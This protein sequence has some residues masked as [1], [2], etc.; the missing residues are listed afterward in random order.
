MLKIQF[1]NKSSYYGEPKTVEVLIKDIPKKSMLDNLIRINS[2]DPQFVK[3]LNRGFGDEPI[4][5][6]IDQPLMLAIKAMGYLKRGRYES[7]DVYSS[8][9]LEFR[10]YMALPDPNK[11]WKD[12]FI[13][14]MCRHAIKKTIVSRNLNDFYIQDYMD[15]ISLTWSRTYRVISELKPCDLNETSFMH[16]AV[17][18]ITRDYVQV[19]KIPECDLLNRV[20]IPPGYK[21]D[22]FTPGNSGVMPINYLCQWWD[23][24]TKIPIPIMSCRFLYIGVRKLIDEDDCDIDG[25]EKPSS[26][27]LKP[28]GPIYINTSFM[29]SKYREET[30]KRSNMDEYGHRYCIEYKICDKKIYFEWINNGTLMFSYR[31]PNCSISAEKWLVI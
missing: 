22:V 23:G 24:Y 20:V 25:F 31:T 18:Y 26:K 3:K 15:R 13:R 4:R 8:E 14:A 21:L 11:W 16:E 1:Y 29:S 28:I 6:E 17:Y 27:N 9:M 12:I 19:Y 30:D 5:I 10:D 2:M 7:D